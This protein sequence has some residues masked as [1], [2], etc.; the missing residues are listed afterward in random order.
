MGMN[1][2]YKKAFTGQLPLYVSALIV[3]T[4]SWCMVSPTWAGEKSNLLD[5][6]SYVGKNGEVGQ[7]LAEY[8]DEEIIFQDGLFTSASCEPYN[9]GSSPY[10]TKIVDEKIHFDAVTESPTHG[11]ISWQGIIDGEQ[12][13]VSFVWTK[14]RWYWDTR[15]EY[16]FRGKLKE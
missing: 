2:S 11:K 13:E 7:E 9:F 6:R 12:V 10:N 3:L 4:L 16:W 5:G 1:S 14:E 8:E 15:R